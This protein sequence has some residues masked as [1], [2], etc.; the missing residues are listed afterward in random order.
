MSLFPNY[1]LKNLINKNF[2]INNIK[3][4]Y[5]YGSGIFPQKD[6]K[7]KMIDLIFIV[8]NTA[9]FHDENITKNKTH[10]SKFALYL[11]P[12]LNYFNENGTKV[13]YNPSVLLD[14]RTNIKYGV[15][16][17]KNFLQGLNTWNSLFV[18]GRFHKPVLC[19][20]DKNKEEEIIANQSDRK[21]NFFC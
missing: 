7:P 4:I 21:K 3:Y 6:N 19:F 8:E 2:N 18:S 5:G 13:Y 17:Q 14:N 10:Y 20:Y 12:C 9:K 11:K 1:N 15:I 16:S